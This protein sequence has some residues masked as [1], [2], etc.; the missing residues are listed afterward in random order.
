M[1]FF[2]RAIFT[3]VFYHLFL[4]HNIF[5]FL[6]ASTHYYV[7]YVLKYGEKMCLRDNEKLDEKK[8]FPNRN[9]R[10]NVYMQNFKT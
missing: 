2:E 10:Y 3:Y 1:I 8:Y 4:S 6:L 7:L 5:L 9:T